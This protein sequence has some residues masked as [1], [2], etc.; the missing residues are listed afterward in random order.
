MVLTSRRASVRP[1]SDQRNPRAEWPGASDFCGAVLSG[2]DG[3]TVGRLRSGA[4]WLQVEAEADG[5]RVAGHDLDR[6]VHVVVVD[7]LD[8]LDPQARPG[9]HL[10]HRQ[11][12]T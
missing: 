8:V 3:A 4:E 11:A 2:V 5:G 6:H 9:G 12:E 10:V 7:R 1:T